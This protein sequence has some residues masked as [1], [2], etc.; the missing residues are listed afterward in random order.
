MEYVDEDVASVDPVAVEAAVFVLAPVVAEPELDLS[1][2]CVL[3]DVDVV[4]A[5]PVVDDVVTPVLDEV[6]TFML[7]EVTIFVVDVVFCV[8]V[9]VLCI[10]VFAVDVCG[11]LLLNTAT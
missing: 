9:V 4:V 6:V 2:D 3:V 7:D 5:T 1:V 11:S 10:D 8:D